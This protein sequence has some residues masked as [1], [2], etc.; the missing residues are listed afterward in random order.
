MDKTVQLHTLCPN[1]LEIPCSH[2]MPHVACVSMTSLINIYQVF[3]EKNQ[4]LNISIEDFKFP[5]AYEQKCIN[6]DTHSKT[7]SCCT[8]NT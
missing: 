3:T 4:S 1:C 5:W 8:I 7:E 6:G 2:N